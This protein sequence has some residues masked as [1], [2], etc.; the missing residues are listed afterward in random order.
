[1]SYSPGTTLSAVSNSS[2]LLQAS[3]AAFSNSEINS[4]PHNPELE[5]KSSLVFFPSVAAAIANP[6]E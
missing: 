5:M 6:V 4:L 3:S 1:M 2:V